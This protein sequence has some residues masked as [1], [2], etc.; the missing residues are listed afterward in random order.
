MSQSLN[1]LFLTVET[2][3]AKAVQG[4][5]LSHYISLGSRTAFKSLCLILVEKILLYM[6]TIKLNCT[7]LFLKRE[8]VGGKHYFSDQLLVFFFF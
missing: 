2:L 8:R 5:S 7:T 4:E 1:V 6:K 3:R